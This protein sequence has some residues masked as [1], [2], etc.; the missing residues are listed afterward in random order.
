[1]SIRLSLAIES[2]GFAVPENGKIAVFNPRAEHD[3][4]VLPEDRVL[5][6]QP[7]RPDHDAFADQGYDCAATLEPGTEIAAAVVFLPRG[8]FPAS[9]KSAGTALGGTGRGN[10]FRSGAD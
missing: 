9:C 1:M 10:Q 3:L 4:T 7:M 5:V 6:V 8:G 2:G